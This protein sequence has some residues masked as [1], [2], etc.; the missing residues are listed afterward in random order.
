[1]AEANF[2]RKKTFGFINYMIN[3]V[4]F[5]REPK[6]LKM[7]TLRDFLFKVYNVELKK[8]RRSYVS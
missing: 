4:N 8:L 2:E 5:A 3:L 6:N 1:M 7:F